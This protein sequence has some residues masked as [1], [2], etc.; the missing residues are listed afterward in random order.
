MTSD[1][2]DTYNNDS[3]AFDTLILSHFNS[4]TYPVKAPAN[5][6]NLT[7]VTEKDEKLYIQRILNVL[8]ILGGINYLPWSEYKD[9]SVFPNEF[10]DIFAYNR[11]LKR[12]LDNDIQLFN[13]TGNYAVLGIYDKDTIYN[14][15]DRVIAYNKECDDSK[16]LYKIY[17]CLRNNTVNIKPSDKTSITYYESLVLPKNK[18]KNT[19]YW[20]EDNVTLDSF[21]TGTDGLTWDEFNSKPIRDLK[22]FSFNNANDF[23]VS[24]TY[25]SANL[26]QLSQPT[27]KY[28]WPTNT[29]V[30]FSNMSVS[31]LLSSDPGII[32]YKNDDSVI[33]E[34]KEAEAADYIVSSVISSYVINDM[35]GTVWFKL[36][37]SGWIEQ[38]GTQP[39]YI[40]SQTSSVITEAGK[41]YLIGTSNKSNMC[42]T[43]DINIP[44]K[45][46]ECLSFIYSVNEFDITNLE[47]AYLRVYNKQVILHEKSN[48]TIYI[49]GLA[50]KGEG[51]G[52]SYI[53][54]PY[55]IF[56]KDDILV[57]SYITWESKGISSIT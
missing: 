11:V 53:E 35:E 9:V 4:G 45:D 48:P 57:K 8:S 36:Y 56:S 34:T 19:I 2:T 49:A 31:N 24:A 30:I 1:N 37:K 7:N 46:I 47:N 39:I 51:K 27:K 33:S 29:P 16:T 20:A 55:D 15:G 14:E 26:R 10:S 50:L 13:N 38:G 22:S 40:D 3:N 41:T 17:V 23:T 18:I 25:E 32:L 44:I 6:R 21:N 54:K 52:K 12:L 42:I 43:Q 5:I 28:Q